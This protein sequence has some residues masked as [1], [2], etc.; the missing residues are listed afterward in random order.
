MV[1]SNAKKID[2]LI[3]Y[4][5]LYLH[6]ILLSI[7]PI[8]FLYSESVQYFPLNIVVK[9][10][11][12]VSAVTLLLMTTVWLFVKNIN[13]SVIIVSLFS[14]SFFSFGYTLNVSQFVTTHIFGYTLRGYEYEAS[15]MAIWFL[16]CAVVL[17]YTVKKVNDLRT[18]NK[19]LTKMSVSLII[20][21]LINLTLIYVRATSVKG[22]KFETRVDNYN[23]DENTTTGNKLP[24]I[25][26][27][28]LDGFGGGDVLE[29]VYGY[30]SKY[31][32]HLKDKGFYEAAESTSNYVHTPLSL[33]S[34]LNLDY[35]DGFL[36]VDRY[37]SSF[38]PAYDAIQKSKIVAI[39]KGRGY[40]FVVISSGYY[41]TQITSADEYYS[42]SNRLNEFENGI[43]NTTP[44]PLIIN[45]LNITTKVDTN[46][47]YRSMTLN[48]FER[49]KSISS[50]TAPKFI[51]A[52]IEAPHPPFV[53]GKDGERVV[54]LSNAGDLDGPE[55]IIDK[56]LG[57]ERYQKL[58]RDQATFVAKMTVDM[59]NS[60]LKRSNDSVIIIQADHGP[61]SLLEW[62]NLNEEGA[63]EIFSILNLY[64]FP[65]KDYTDLYKSITPVNSFRV[66][67]NKYLN[68]NFDILDDVNYYSIPERPYD[69]TDVTDALDR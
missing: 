35:V 25:F 62:D 5:Q 61:R 11:I 36:D 1:I 2:K 6:P 66:V 63:K 18:V 29:R 3:S 22:V 48:A 45:M 47:I 16:V 21:V 12:F 10:I 15:T 27:V 33:S 23:G 14:F 42:S 58:Y 37:D 4:I 24:D 59:I 8:L 40:K 19:Y 64:Y 52:H 69:L 38:L 68:T 44:I 32:N 26:Y 55:L 46:N 50:D 49:L 56:K 54:Y 51:F 28:I 20:V 43:I 67:A 65:D 13:I 9:P 30:D 41:G 39:L 57:K 31:I 34:S 7:F 53:F 60:I 17:Y